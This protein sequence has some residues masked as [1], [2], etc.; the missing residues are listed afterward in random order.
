MATNV[1][2]TTVH[3]DGAPGSIGAGASICGTITATAHGV[4]R[5]TAVFAAAAGLTVDETG[6][7]TVTGQKLNDS[8]DLDA[9]EITR[10]EIDCT[11]A[12]TYVFKHNDA[13]PITVK[14]Y[15]VVEVANV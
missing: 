14:R 10:L 13:G 7:A 15:K 3:Y 12:G 8:T 4:L 6:A 9:D 5:I 11:K 1:Y 2:A